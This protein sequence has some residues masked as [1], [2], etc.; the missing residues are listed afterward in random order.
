MTGC[1]LTCRYTHKKETNPIPYLWHF[2]KK[3]RKL[4]FTFVDLEKQK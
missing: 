1:I 3:V 2:F 4:K